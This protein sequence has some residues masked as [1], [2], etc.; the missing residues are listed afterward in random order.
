MLSQVI[1]ALGARR[2]ECFFWATHAGAELDLLVV[3][4]RKRVAFEFK[5]TVAPCV[6]RSIQ[7]AMATLH[8]DRL[9]V[10]HAGSKT[11]EIARGIRAIAAS[12]VFEAIKPL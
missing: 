1:R 11:F 8:L 3:R 2:E 7:S 4:G 12:R 6:T 10:V 9:D 5:R